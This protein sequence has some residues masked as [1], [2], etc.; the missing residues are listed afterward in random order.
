MEEVE[1]EF[2]ITQKEAK[3]L[4]DKLF[5]VQ[6]T[7]ESLDYFRKKKGIKYTTEHRGDDSWVCDCPSFKFK[8][9]LERIEMLDTGKVHE[10]TCKHMRFVMKKEGMPYKRLYRRI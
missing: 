5:G 10:E 8:T 7:V 9:G 2:E 4:W 3:Q 1:E 6:Y